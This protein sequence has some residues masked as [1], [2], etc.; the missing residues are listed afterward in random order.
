VPTPA[1]LAFYW[2]AMLAALGTFFPLYSLYLSENLGLSGFQTGVVTAAIPLAG[3][4]AQPLW[5]SFADRSGSRVRVLAFLTA[6]A[7]AG[8]FHLSSQRTFA[9]VLAATVVLAVFSTSVMPMSV[10]VSLA[11][12]RER[13]RHA[14]GMVRSVG[15]L[16][17]LVAVA[18]FP[19]VV[20]ALAGF[21]TPVESAA[22][23][24]TEPRLGLMLTVASTWMALASVIAF[25]LPRKGAV[26][27][28][29]EA[30][31]WRHLLGSGPYLRLLAVTFVTYLFL[32]GPLVM[33]PMFVRSLGGDL[34][35]VSRMWV[36]MLAFEIPLLAGVAAAPERIGARELIGIGIAAD[37]LRWLVSSLSSSLQVIYVVQVFHGLAVAG[38]VVGSALYVEAVIPG[39]L[40]STAQG[41]VYMA[42]VSLGGIVSS[43]V[44]G[45][46]IDAFGPRA[47]GLV[48]GAGGALLAL[49]LPWILP[50]VSRHSHD[51]L[52]AME[53]VD[54][55]PTV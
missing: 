37:A 17:Y 48:G 34:E 4:F 6:A 55:R 18:S 24:A 16:G 44:S 30:G 43:V 5:G 23:T 21:A 12:L 35:T 22:R 20:H 47:P 9:N 42:G 31:D 26:A 2:F 29:S 11:L 13:G 54:E 40:R 33:F 36:W 1:V 8:Y 45:A 53:A 52:V 41:L 39:R 15:T 19:M 51:D 49:V 50:A 32:Q 28:R 3:M 14:F 27:L 7:A 10:A 38:F 46:L 25:S